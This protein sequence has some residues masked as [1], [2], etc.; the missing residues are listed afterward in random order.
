MTD[1]LLEALTPA[2]LQLTFHALE[3]LAAQP[4]AEEQ[5]GLEALTRIEAEVNEARRRFES[6]DPENNLVAKEYQKKLQEKLVEF[7]R[8][9]AKRAKVTK[10]SAL[11]PTEVGR[12]KWTPCVTLTPPFAAA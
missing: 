2:Q 12:Q 9:K 10:Q 5:Q 11:C 4:K 6:I 8:M 7:N 1:A 3:E